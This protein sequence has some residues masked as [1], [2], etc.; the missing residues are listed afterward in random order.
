MTAASTGVAIRLAV[1]WVTLVLSA[2]GCQLV[3][4][5]PR[6]P[7]QRIT[8]PAAA[9]SVLIAVT[10]RDSPSA[11]AGMARLILAAVRPGERIFIMDD[12]GG[13]VLASAAAPP[14]PAITIQGPPS[15]LA[16]GATDFQKSLHSRALRAYRSRI[17][18]AVVQLRALEELRLAAWARGLITQADANLK[19]AEVIDGGIKPALVAALAEI[20]SLRQAGVNLGTRIAIALLGIDSVTARSAVRPPAG[21][22]GATVLVDDFP[23]TAQEEAEW[24]AS[25]LRSGAAQAVML[26]AATDDELPMLVTRALAK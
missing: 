6:G 23:G 8:L 21:L 12:R 14:P 2:T 9:P 20:S 19:R 5:S 1:V 25:F 17:A 24:R 4:V 11:V 22:R 13:A 26:T 16:E 3:T 7:G 15:P 18:R 10:D